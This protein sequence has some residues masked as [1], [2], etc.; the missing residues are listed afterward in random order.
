MLW[1]LIALLLL[2]ALYLFLIAP[3]KRPDDRALRGWL[4]AH[5]GLHDGNRS[6]PE[7]SLEAFRRAAEA[8]YGVELDV[9]LTR[10]GMLVVHHDASLKRHPQPQL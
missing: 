5:R 2:C 7:N 8:G 3:A 1:L 10:D 6:V 4:Y 9:Q